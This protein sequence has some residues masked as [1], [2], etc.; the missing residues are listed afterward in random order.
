M[1]D[2]YAGDFSVGRR[3]QGSLAEFLVRYAA[4]LG[5]DEAA[6]AGLRRGA[7]KLR[8]LDYDWK[9]NDWR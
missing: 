3:G 9:F 5:L 8:F 1:F 6:V 4:A 7:I 2:W